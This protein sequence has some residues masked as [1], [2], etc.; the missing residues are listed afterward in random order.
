MKRRAQVGLLLALVA[1]WAWILFRGQGGA[2]PGALLGQSPPAGRASAAGKGGR[3]PDAVLR[4]DRLEMEKSSAAPDARRN[5]FEYGGRA[6]VA[7]APPPVEDAPPPPPPRPPAPPVRFY[8]FAEPSRGGGK[9]VFLT[10]GDEIYVVA[11][12]D[13]IQRRYRLVRVGK[14]NVEVEEV[15]GA[16]RWTVPLEQ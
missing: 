6:Q 5:I 4:I 7:V 10:D 13:V 11:E 9:R 2:D 1:V 12:G 16:R 3:I 14:D 8:G 15:S